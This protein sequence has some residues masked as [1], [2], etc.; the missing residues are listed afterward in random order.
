MSSCEGPAT[1]LALPTRTTGRASRRL[2]AAASATI[3]L[4]TSDR[5][6]PTGTGMRI[7]GRAITADHTAGPTTGPGATG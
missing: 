4:R 5:G 7:T 3:R 1:G 6:P 2:A